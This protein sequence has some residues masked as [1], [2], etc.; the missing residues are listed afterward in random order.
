MKTNHSGTPKEEMDKIMTDWPSGSYLVVECKKLK[1]FMVVPSHYS[2]LIF[3]Y[4]HHPSNL[5]WYDLID[6]HSVIISSSS[7][8]SMYR[9]Q[10]WK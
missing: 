8:M 6:P 5:E 2:T 7:I 4:W 3:S 9:E 10:I 1:L